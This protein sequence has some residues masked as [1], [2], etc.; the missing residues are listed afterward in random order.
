MKLGTFHRAALTLAGTMAAATALAQAGGAPAGAQSGLDIP[1]DARFLAKE[2]PA[3]RKATAIVNGTV[4]TGTD[5]DHRMAL[6]RLANNNEIP[7]EEE[8]RL[9][10][11]VLRN[12]VDET[13]QIHAAE[14][15]DM[16]VEQKDVDAYFARY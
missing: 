9:R 7:A 1:Q 12:L 2:D 14:A 11:Q 15:Q 8:A 10:A 5:I 16:K 3:I 13:L 4:I 6:I